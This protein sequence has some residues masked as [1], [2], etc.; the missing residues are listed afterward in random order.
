MDIETKKAD[1]D[2]LKKKPRKSAKSATA[3]GDQ[4]L[5]AV[6][7]QVP[8]DQTGLMFTHLGILLIQ[9]KKMKLTVY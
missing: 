7:S 8:L 2:R 9:Q 6:L 1:L 4:F 5:E 3:C